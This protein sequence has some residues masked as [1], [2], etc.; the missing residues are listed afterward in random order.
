ME[1]GKRYV[2]LDLAKRMMEVCI[3]TGGETGVKRVSGM[4]TGGNGWRGWYGSL[5]LCICVG[6]V[7]TGGSRL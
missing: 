5:R 6:A 7:S 4:K 3:V 2:G 1:A